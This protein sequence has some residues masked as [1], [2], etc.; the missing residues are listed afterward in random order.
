MPDFDFGL[1]LI[2]AVEEIP[3][4]R[5]RENRLVDI[6]EK[7]TASPRSKDNM[8]LIVFGLS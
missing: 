8:Q 7:F 1:P 6:Q 2:G 5:P 3:L 4:A